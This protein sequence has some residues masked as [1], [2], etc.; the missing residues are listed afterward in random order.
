MSNYHFIRDIELT[1][2]VEIAIGYVLYA[3]TY[4]EREFINCL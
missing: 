3:K 1:N 2:I 4:I